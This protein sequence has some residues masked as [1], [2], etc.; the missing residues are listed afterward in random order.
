VRLS[1]SSGCIYSAQYTRLD[2]RLFNPFR[3]F[4]CKS[5]KVFDFGQKEKHPV[6]LSWY[7]GSA[8]ESEYSPLDLETIN[9]SYSY[10][11]QAEALLTGY[12]LQIGSF[13]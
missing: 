11:V 4:C 10:K 13:Y 5:A 3:D 9:F 6:G 12:P 7:S 8:S 1:R 2:N